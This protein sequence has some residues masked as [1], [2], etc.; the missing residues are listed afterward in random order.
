[1]KPKKVKKDTQANRFRRT[2]AWRNKSIEIREN[3]NYLCAV[4]LKEERF[5]YEDIGVH[6][7]VPLEVDFSL[8]LENKNLIP[9]CSCHHEQAEAG[10]ITK[11]ELY[12]LVEDNINKR[13]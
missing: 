12:K 7:I 1:M 6:H 9:L 10:E 5:T 8:R 11:D 13:R 3:F 2:T 4:C